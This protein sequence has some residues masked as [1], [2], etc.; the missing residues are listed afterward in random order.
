VNTQELQ[1]YGLIAL[2]PVLAGVIIFLY[3]QLGK[4]N[5][6]YE[7][8]QEKRI[9]EI[10]AARDDLS[11]LLNKISNQQEIAN[12]QYG[13]LINSLTKRGE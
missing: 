7:N 6:K 11:N 5:T 2:I 9:E 4:A 1:Q 8:M 10:K 13:T 12:T 3:N